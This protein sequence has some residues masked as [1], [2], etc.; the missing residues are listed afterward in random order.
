MSFDHSGRAAFVTHY[1]EAGRWEWERFLAPEA[2]T[3]WERRR[4]F[5]VI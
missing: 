4:Y 3:E 5:E 2:V 1:A